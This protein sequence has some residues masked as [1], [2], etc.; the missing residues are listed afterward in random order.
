MSISVCEIVHCIHTTD[1]PK[2]DRFS[3][4]EDYGF[5]QFKVRGRFKQIPYKGDTKS[6]IVSE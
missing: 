4:E 5:S 2:D 6:L 1:A 3:Q